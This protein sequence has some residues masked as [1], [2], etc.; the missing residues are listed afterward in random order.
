MAV[1]EPGRLGGLIDLD[2]AGTSDT[3]DDDAAL[4]ARTMTGNRREDMVAVRGATTYVPRLTRRGPA[5]TPTPSLRLDDGDTVLITGG[6]GGLGLRLVEWLMARGARHFLLCARRAP[7]DA[8]GQH[9]DRLRAMGADI[10]ILQVDVADAAALKIALDR[11]STAR[12]PVTVVMHLAGVLD[13][14]PLQEQT[15][16]R[17]AAVFAPKV[18][19]AWNLHQAFAGAALKHF[20][21]FSSVSALMPAPG[22]SSYAAANAFLD[23]LAH[24][25]HALGWP[26]L[27]MNWGPWSE[28]GHAETEYGRRAHARLAALGVGSIRPDVG[29]RALER[30]MMAVDAHPQAVAVAVD[31][32]TLGRVDPAAARLGLVADLVSAPPATPMPS[33]QIPGVA[34]DGPAAAAPGTAVL[35][36]ALVAL[37]RDERRPYLLRYLSDMVVAALR[38]RTDE[39]IDAR[40]RLFDIG[41]DSI[42]ALEM[43]DRLARAL[44]APLSATLLF[45]HPT[46]DAL[47]EYILAELVPA[48]TDE[49]AS[50][51]GQ[52]LE[53]ELTRR[54]LREIEI[55]RG[56]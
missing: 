22:Q 50:P 36:D 25:R 51:D 55:S 32:T 35:R 54:L 9:I 53:D 43:K 7:S 23:A 40:Q 6:T 28:A 56:T 39:P 5:N 37:P 15:W 29:F 16:E 4:I 31:W 19:G 47:C 38:L 41:L 24:H 44:N 30:A 14:G 48:A 20:V 45:V 3:A 26:A 52:A 42:V 34:N 13:D 18:A 46:L 27:T 12:P 49:T 21:M 10:E 8:T 2:P 11:A 17:C 33:T 1:D